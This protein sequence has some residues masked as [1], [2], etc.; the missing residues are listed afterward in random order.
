MSFSVAMFSV[1]TSPLDSPGSTKDA[2]GMNVYM[3]ELATKLGQRQ[4]TVD[5]FTRWTNEN[6][7]RIVQLSTNV[8]VIHIKAGPITPVHKNDLFH[9]LPEYI[10]NI[11]AFRRSQARRYDVLH[12]HYWLSGVA[13]T[14][15][16]KRWDIPHVTMFHTLARLKQL[17]NPNEKEPAL[18]LEM[19]QQV[20]K[21]ADRIIAATADE[22][23]QLIRY[24]GA[25]SNQVKVIPCGVDL[26]LFVP[27][28]KLAART[29]LRLLPSQPV[30]LFV[31]RLDPFKGPDLLLQ[32]AAMME[33]DAQV[34][35]VGGQLD[36]D[37]ELAQLK[38]LASD[39][40]INE[41]VHF[42]GA[43]PQQDLPEIYSAADVTVVPSY[44][45]SF[46]LVA[47]E[48]L[49]CGTPVVATRAGGLTTIVKHGETGYLV[50]HCPGF[51]A[52]RLDTLLQDHAL[53]ENM[54][55]AAR[56]SVRQFSWNSVADQVSSLYQ[57][58]ISETE[59]LL[60]Q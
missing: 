29:A 26:R 20:I 27:Q 44:H 57:E 56:P 19:E 18:R 25:N 6:S 53:L 39:L 7:P 51:F 9:Y 15:L 33:E 38:T 52:E 47:V 46:G 12:S 32:A 43:R 41:R 21:Q 31:G 5:I 55:Q 50:P 14:Q 34:V 48:S 1:H 17:A 60:A 16:A 59:Q 37:E 45:E 24:C 3:R 30:L 49:A 4:I 13:A 40:N 11:E 10:Q 36:G 42:F 22:R 28:N 8:R 35:I 58:T 2:G 23:A 54:R